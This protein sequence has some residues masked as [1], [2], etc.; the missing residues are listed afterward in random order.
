MRQFVKWQ[1][2]LFVALAV[3][4]SVPPIRSGKGR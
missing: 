4:L 2:L 1:A 3:F